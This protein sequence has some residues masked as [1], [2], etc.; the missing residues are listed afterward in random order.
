MAAAPISSRTRS[1]NETAVG[2]EGK[3]ETA[4]CVP[5]S[6]MTIE[7]LA[8]VAFHHHITLLATNKEIALP[9]LQGTL[10]HKSNNGRPTKEELKIWVQ[11]QVEHVANPKTSDDTP[12]PSPKPAATGSSINNGIILGNGNN[13]NGI[14]VENIV[15]SV[16]RALDNRKRDADTNIEKPDGKR[17]RADTCIIKCNRVMATGGI[18]GTSITADQSN[19]SACNTYRWDESQSSPSLSS[20][21]L[22]SSLSS[23]PLPSSSSS[24]SSLTPI[25]SAILQSSSQINETTKR[26]ISRGEYVSVNELNPSNYNDSPSLIVT[27]DGTIQQRTVSKKVTSVPQFISNIH[28]LINYM[29]SLAGDAADERLIDGVTYLGQLNQLGNEYGIEAMHHYD[30]YIRSTRAINGI[31]QTWSNTDPQAWVSAQTLSRAIHLS[32]ASSTSSS[33][34]SSSSPWSATRRVAPNK[35]SNCMGFNTRKGCDQV[36]CKWIHRC[37]NCGGEHSLMTCTNRGDRSRDS[38]DDKGSNKRR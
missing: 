17:R 20:S 4:V 34:S 16:L 13:N 1:Q 24:S 7:E 37:D 9:Q 29:A 11:K 19:C 14:T 22:S 10:G 5:L 38:R 30:H 35:N 31:T 32:S 23:G 8:A 26:K 36:P 2:P 33:P 18:C 12:K 3:G 25:G 28:R 6:S 27:A 21:G 15:E